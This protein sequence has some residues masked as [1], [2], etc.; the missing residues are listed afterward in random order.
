VF[1]VHFWGVRGSLPVSGPEFH[2]YGGNTFCVEVQCGE[3]RLL[4]DAGSGLLPAS[5]ALMAEGIMNYNLFFSHCHYD[6]IIGL[7]YFIP[8]YSPD[9]DVT[10]WAGHMTNGMTTREMVSEFI[11]PPWFPIRIDACRANMKFMDFKMG[12]EINALPGIGI[13]TGKL[14]H[15]GNAVGYRI[16][17]QGRTV[18]IIT[19]TEHDPGGSLDPNVLALIEG[20]DVFL[21]DSMYTDDEMARH[22]GFGHSSWQ[23]AL[24]LAKASGAKKVGFVHHSPY[25]TDAELDMIDRKARK[26]FPGAFAVREGDVLD[27]A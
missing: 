9:A 12:D 16:E 11:K 1:R 22:R 4:F 25:R 17:Y 24:K 5:K 18:A 7:P 27:V 20:V 6:H 3:Q 8:I 26:I 2:R 10:M 14:D 21:Y 13:R 23:H 19:D 15:P